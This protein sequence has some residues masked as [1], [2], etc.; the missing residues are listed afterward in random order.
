MRRNPAHANRQTH[1]GT[2]ICKWSLSHQ[3]GRKMDFKIVFPNRLIEE[4]IFELRVVGKMDG[5]VLPRF[6]QNVI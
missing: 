1:C 4:I 3:T 5:E 2:R 6:S